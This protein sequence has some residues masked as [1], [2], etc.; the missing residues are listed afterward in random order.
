[1]GA[2]ILG[3]PLVFQFYGFIFTSIMVI[4]FST[5]T[6]FSVHCLLYCN[7]ITNHSGY[8]MFAKICYG[9]LGNFLVKLVIIINNF[10]IT[11][12]YFFIFGDVVSGVVSSFLGSEDLTESNFW[13]HNWHNWI[14]IIFVGVIMAPFIFKEKLDA[15]KVRTFILILSTY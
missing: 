8:S 9:N 12:G 11:C 15:L 10:G 5:I 14:Y 6:I 1:M 13:A 3:I 7:K 2:G 4:A